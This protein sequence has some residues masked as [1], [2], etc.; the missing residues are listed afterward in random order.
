MADRVAH[1]GGAGG[2]I[3]GRR[4]EFERVREQT[5]HGCAV[6]LA[7]QRVRADGDRALQVAREPLTHV[8]Q[9]RTG[10]E[11]RLER[12]AAQDADHHVQESRGRDVECVQ[13]GGYG[14]HRDDRRRIA[15]EHGRIRTEIPQEGRDAR[16]QADPRGERRQEQFRGLRER[17][18]QQQ[19]DR[20]AD[21]GTENPVLAL[22]QPHAAAALRD[23]PHGR[24]GPFRVVEIHPEG[25]VERQQRRGG[26]AQGEAEGTR[27]QRGPRVAQ[28]GSDS[29]ER[30]QMG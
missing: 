1:R 24:R 14:V 15:R 10:C 7:T 8:A 29:L 18:G 27:R 5:V 2:R 11:H 19:R 13:R 25:N 16:A 26:V 4:V 21:R 9:R 20:R 28:R 6:R 17:A 3:L 12:R 30:R 22:R 23:D